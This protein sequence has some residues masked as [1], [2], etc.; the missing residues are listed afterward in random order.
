MPSI[1]NYCLT[2][3]GASASA[4]DVARSADI[5][6]TSSNAAHV[7]SNI[8]D[9]DGQSYW[10]SGFD[11]AAPVDVQLH[12]GSAI[13]IKAIEIDWEYPAQ[14]CLCD[15]SFV[16][17]RDS[18]FRFERKAYE[19]QVATGGKWTSVYATSGN[20]AQATKYVGPGVSGSALRLRMTKVHSASWFV[21]VLVC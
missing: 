10:T 9:G 19:L 16:P 15:I 18:S 14:A 20:N 13:Q 6:A 4:N 8:V 7:V 11:P 17:L 2:M 1:G 3:V 21:H 12:F 5:D